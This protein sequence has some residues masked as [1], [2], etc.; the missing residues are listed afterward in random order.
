MKL[1]ITTA[2]FKRLLSNPSIKPKYPITI[3]LKKVSKTDLKEL[4]D[5]L[6]KKA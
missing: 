4:V 5:L 2:Q 1:T 3:D 6:K